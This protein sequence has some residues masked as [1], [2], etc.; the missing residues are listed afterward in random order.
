MSPEQIGLAL[1][2]ILRGKGRPVTLYV[3]ITPGMTSGEV[4]A[5]PPRRQTAWRSAGEFTAGIDQ[6]DFKR[7]LEA[8]EQPL[9]GRHYQWRYGLDAPAIAG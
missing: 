4:S 1:A 7:R 6:S 9:L 8:V 3:R 5:N 2:L